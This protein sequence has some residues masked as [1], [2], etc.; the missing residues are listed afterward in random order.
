[1]KP[2]PIESR[3]EVI[4][5]DG[6]QKCFYSAVNLDDPAVLMQTESSLQNPIRDSINRWS[7]L[8]PSTHSK[9][10]IALSAVPVI[11]SIK[12]RQRSRD[13]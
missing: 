12:A 4:N 1:L 3:L 10:L 7:M 5:Y 8:L 2:G 6:A 11:E 13:F 9:T